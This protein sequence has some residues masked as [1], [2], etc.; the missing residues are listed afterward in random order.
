[1]QIQYLG[2]SG[3]AI[4]TARSLIIAD[5]YNPEVNRQLEPQIASAEHVLVLA[6]HAHR[7]HYNPIVRLWSR[8]GRKV[9][10]V[11]ANDIPACAGTASIAPNQR[12]SFGDVEVL[13][14]GSTDEGVSFGIREG[15]ACIFHAGDLNNWHWSEEST[16]EEIDK[17]EADFLHIVAKIKA[18]LN[19]IDVAF[20]PVDPR[21]GTD[22]FRG[23]VQFARELKPK[24]LV[25]M[26]FGRALTAPDEFY[27]AVAAYTTVLKVS[28]PGDMLT[29]A[30]K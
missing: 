11:F 24:A 18:E 20:F 21:M 26:H 13:S 3:F 4:S 16:Q 15:G 23:A 27:N 1:M 28:K 9:D 30:G 2:N 14:F 10:F 7:D 8:L 17:A 19:N 25:P 5:C 29:I 12:M 6:S 22:Y